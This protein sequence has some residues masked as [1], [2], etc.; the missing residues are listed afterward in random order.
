MLAKTTQFADNTAT[1]TTPLCGWEKKNVTARNKEKGNMKESTQSTE[2]QQGDDFRPYTRS[3][4]AS[5]FSFLVLELKT[6]DGRGLKS[7]RK[8]WDLGGYN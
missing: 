2:N 3:F 8:D 4:N 5:S 7:G 6:F 1:A